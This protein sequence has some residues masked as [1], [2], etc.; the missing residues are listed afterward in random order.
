MDSKLLSHN[1]SKLL[2]YIS[3]SLVALSI[4]SCCARSDYNI[5]CGFL[6][7]FLRSYNSNDKKKFFIKLVL[8]ILLLASIFDIIWIIKFATF[9]RHGEET[10]ELWQSL[11]N[12]HNTVYFAGIFEFLLKIPLIYF[13]YLQFRAF[14]GVTGE[15]FSLKYKNTY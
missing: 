10:S 7:L 15:L 2:V 5:L 8:H 11:S 9:W 1:K 13:C 14:G 4:L 6:M 3:W 12:I